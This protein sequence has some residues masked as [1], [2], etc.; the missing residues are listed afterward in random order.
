MIA[1]TLV[2]LHS[3]DTTHIN[4]EI[5]KQVEESN[6]KSNMH[7]TPG[8]G[9]NRQ[10]LYRQAKLR[11]T[12]GAEKYLSRVHLTSDKGQLL[13]AFSSNNIL[14]VRNMEM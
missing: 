4:C 11:G 1:S 12:S 5:L 3:I 8:V 10:P 14:T 6:R 7:M 9:K 13:I 2:S